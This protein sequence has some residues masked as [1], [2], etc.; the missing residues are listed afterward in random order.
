MAEPKA[1]VGQLSPD[2]YTLDI[3]QGNS[4]VDLNTCTAAVFNVMKADGTITTWTA[5]FRLKTT[6][7]IKLYHPYEA[8][9]LSLPGGVYSIYATLTFPT[10]PRITF[11]KPLYV[12]ERFDLT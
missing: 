9:D 7:L 1:Y 11:P 12:K 5:T 2:E 6:A 10:G 3:P 8:G 4:G